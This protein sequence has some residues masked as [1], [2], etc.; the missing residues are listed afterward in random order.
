M[1]GTHL[2][3]VCIYIHIWNFSD[4][5]QKVYLIAWL[6][7]LMETMD[8]HWHCYECIIKRRLMSVFSRWLTMIPHLFSPSS[9]SISF[10][11]ID[12]WILTFNNNLI[13]FLSKQYILIYLYK[14]FY[15]S[16]MA[17]T[18]KQSRY[19]KMLIFLFFYCQFNCI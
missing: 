15:I 2:R 6:S 16:K 4:V 19:I 5:S 17:K 11:S 12:R 7:S 8:A 13:F 18:L 1:G 9:F 10:L 14:K 3:L